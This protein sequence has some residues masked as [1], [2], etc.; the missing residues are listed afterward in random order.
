MFK[1]FKKSFKAQL[2]GSMVGILFIPIIFGCIFTYR[3]FA[4]DHK[5]ETQIELKWLSNTKKDLIEDFFKSHIT[6]LNLLAANSDIV[7][8]FSKA[9]QLNS[10]QKIRINRMIAH[11]TNRED[12]NVS[13]IESTT[14]AIFYQSKPQNDLNKSVYEASFSD[15]PLSE[16]VQNATQSKKLSVSDFRYDP[17]A[18]EPVLFMALPVLNHRREV[19]GVIALQLPQTSIDQILQRGL[20]LKPKLQVYLVDKNGNVLSTAG[21]QKQ[22]LSIKISQFTNFDTCTRIID[23]A[24]RDAFACAS[25]VSFTAFSSGQFKWIVV[26]QILYDQFSA[27]L[28]NLII[29]FI[30]L[31]TILLLF[32][33]AAAYAVGSRVSRS[34][35]LVISDVQQITNGNLNVD[36][37]VI[38]SD[39]EIGKLTHSLK[40]F[41]DRLKAQ[42]H[43]IM[44]NIN[45]ISSSTSEIS[46]TVS[47]ITASSSE[48]ATA[49]AQTASSSEE[50]SQ[51]ASSFNEKAKESLTVGEKAVEI[52]NQGT[53]AFNQINHGIREVKKQMD[54]VAAMVIDLSKQSQTIGEITAAVKEIAEQSNILAIN[55]SIEATKAGEYGK[56]FAVVANEVRNL[57][58]QSKKSTQQIQN[59]LDSVQESISKT[60]L[61]VEQTNK[62]IDGSVDFVQKAYHSMTD[63]S[64]SIERLINMLSEISDF[65]QEQLVGTSQ[66]KEAMENIKEA[67]TQNLDGMHQLEEVIEDLK[68][69]SENMKS[70]ISIYQLR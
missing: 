32:G 11:I 20:S 31:C 62:T 29:F 12:I 68:K 63:L 35:E 34:I 61:Q 22:G 42:L 59:I 64:S 40:T 60:V 19:L 46:A 47:Q 50:V 55:A 45:V 23:F 65:A 66:I 3:Y 56:G 51:L 15:S 6:Y 8:T 25:P 52:T 36:V 33:A 48:T 67:T 21:S 54:Q 44:E 38:N 4:N 18:N 69:T 30:I 16:A 57:A 37:K 10:A 27:P 28:R 58:D 43:D 53:E 26:S 14:G 7:K 17:F 49:I 5:N 41:V 1:S 2:I 13:F 70:I 39:S 24:Q 9:T